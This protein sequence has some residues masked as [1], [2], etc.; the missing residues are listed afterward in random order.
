MTDEE[1][2]DNNE[3]ALSSYKF[4]ELQFFL[5]TVNKTI[6]PM[7]EKEILFEK[8]FIQFSDH[9]KVDSYI[10]EIIHI[11]KFYRLPYII[12][13]LQGDYKYSPN[14]LT[15]T[16]Y[17]KDDYKKLMDSLKKNK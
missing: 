12:K 5:D 11:M 13:T 7:T 1:K 8:E 4:E 17:S 16:I 9:T 2:K 6:H 10:K 15:T 14:L 3:D